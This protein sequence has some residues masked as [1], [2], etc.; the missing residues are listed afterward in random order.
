MQYSLRAH[1]MLHRTRRLS[2]G[3]TNRTMFLAGWQ[4]R[5]G[6]EIGWDC[7]VDTARSIAIIA[8]ISASPSSPSASGGAQAA[9][10]S[11]K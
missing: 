1:R 11:E 10:Q 9:M 7:P 5:G 2:V 8:R 6:D 4:S 3:A